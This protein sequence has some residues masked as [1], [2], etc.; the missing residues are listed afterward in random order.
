MCLY[1]LRQPAGQPLA[2]LRGS[3]IIAVP[4]DATALC[5]DGEAAR[6]MAVQGADIARKSIW[7][8]AQDLQA[9]R[10][11][12][13]LKPYIGHFSTE[14]VHATGTAGASVPRPSAAPSA[15][16][17]GLAVRER[18]MESGLLDCSPPVAQA[19]PQG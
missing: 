16:H 3:D 17:R 18:R 4:L 11:V 14:C 9:G 7:D 15:V 2:L 10:L 5:D 6:M 12:E 1:R 8:V 19:S 13:V